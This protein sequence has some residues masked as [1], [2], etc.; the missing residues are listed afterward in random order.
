MY[1]FLI[2]MEY[3]NVRNITKV[4]YFLMK[5]L[6]IHPPFRKYFSVTIMEPFPWNIYLLILP[7]QTY[8]IEFQYLII[9]EIFTTF[10]GFIIPVCTLCSMSMWWTTLHNLPSTISNVIIIWWNIIFGN[11]KRAPAAILSLFASSISLTSTQFWS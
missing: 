1:S 7:Q 11:T 5:L 8:I 2:L 6:F 10:H 9:N 3:R 4:L